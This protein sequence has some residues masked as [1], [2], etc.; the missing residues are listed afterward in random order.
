MQQ[1]VIGYCVFYQWQNEVW[2]FAI[3]M[4]IK[5]PAYKDNNHEHC[6]LEF[7]AWRKITD[8]PQEK[9]GIPILYLYLK[10]IECSIRENVFDEFSITEL[11]AEER[12]E[13]LLVFFDDTFEKEDIADS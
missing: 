1:T 12:F 2:L 6:C 4:K 8:F 7:M 9:Q 3:S 13:T 11:K 10:K 5:A